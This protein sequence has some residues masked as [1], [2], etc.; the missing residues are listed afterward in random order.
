M[1]AIERFY[2]KLERLARKHTFID[3]NIGELIPLARAEHERL[4][5]VEAALNEVQKEAHCFIEINPSYCVPNTMLN[6]RLISTAALEAS[7]E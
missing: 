4:K 1:D 6:I 3:E 2:E 5:R 7:H